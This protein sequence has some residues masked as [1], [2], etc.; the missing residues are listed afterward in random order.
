[1]LLYQVVAEDGAMT[2]LLGAGVMDEGRRGDGGGGREVGGGGWNGGGGSRACQNSYPLA[3]ASEFL[4][5]A[6]R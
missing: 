5:G 4:C 1:M 2:L 6:S 3:R